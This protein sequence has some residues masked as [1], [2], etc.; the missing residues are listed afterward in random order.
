[1]LIFDVSLY[2][3]NFLSINELNIHKEIDYNIN[4]EGRERRRIY[5]LFIKKLVRI[6]KLS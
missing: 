6:N 1:M 3:C 4:D 5:V 2:I